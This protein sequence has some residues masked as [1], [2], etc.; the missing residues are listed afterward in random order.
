LQRAFLYEANLRGA[1]LHRANLRGAWLWKAHLHNTILEGA[2]LEGADLTAA[3][4]LTW[5]QL[6]LA[7]IDDTTKLPD[8]LRAT[9]PSELRAAPVAASVA[10][11]MDDYEPADE[12]AEAASDPHA[13]LP[14]KV[15]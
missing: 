6:Q 11:Q 12:A 5:E 1:M 13:A 7:N 8:Y 15:A 3:E 10:P 9:K 2:H 14:T 4:G